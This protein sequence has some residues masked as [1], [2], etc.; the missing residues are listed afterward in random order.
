MHRFHL[1]PER[2]QGSTLTL[3]NGEARHAARVLRVQ[4]GERIT[5]LDGAG[6]EFLCEVSAVTKSEVAL[7]VTEKKTHHAPPFQITLLLAIPKGKIIESIIEKATEL[8]AHRI[9][10]LLTERVA[11]RLTEESAADKGA[12]WQHVAE[13]AIK[14]CGA[15]WLPK[16]E[17]PV[18]LREYLTRGERFDLALV[19]ALQGEARHPREVFREFELQHNTRPR[20]VAVWIGPEGDFTREELVAIQNTGAMPITLGPLVLRVETAAT[21]CLSFLNYE[22]RHKPDR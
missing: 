21:Y 8:G 17:A 13:E 15:A 2:C 19:G 1:P 14:Q 3:T 18:T 20:S 9:V 5:V 11:T 10:P 4:P 7:R 22:L 12:K 16:V 6:G